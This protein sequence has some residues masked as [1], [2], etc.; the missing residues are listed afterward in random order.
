MHKPTDIGP[1]RTGI[2]TSP[3]D[4]KRTIQGAADA[5]TTGVGDARG[6]EAERVRWSSD[7]VPLGTVPPPGTV[8]GVIK[9]VIEK[10]EGHKVT[11]LID[12]LGERL[13]FERTG[14]RLYDALL[15]KFEAAHV[16]Q[17]GP[18]RQAIEQIRDDEV[19]HYALV[20]DALLQVG[21]DPTAM[22]PSADVIGVAGQGW[23]QVLTDPRSTLSQCLVVMLGAEVADA[24]GWEL[25]ATLADA[26]GFDELAT[27][28]K[29][30]LIEE[31][32][33]AVRVRAW[34]TSSVIGQAGIEPTP[35]QHDTSGL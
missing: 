1:N 21:A 4:S 17:G 6:L 30:A 14:A 3:I 20:R 31:E 16:H 5:D 19:R 26:L 33:H 11:V 10:V 27:Q 23:V 29:L 32:E 34:L 8:K 24:E 9:A 13:A 15:A 2:A 7:A 28:F 18:T 22:T 35:A 12:K 25:L